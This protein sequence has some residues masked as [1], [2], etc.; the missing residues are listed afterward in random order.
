MFAKYRLSSMCFW[1]F[2]ENIFSL[3]RFLDDRPRSSIFLK[4]HGSTKNAVNEF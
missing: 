4:K 1:L 3:E 2:G